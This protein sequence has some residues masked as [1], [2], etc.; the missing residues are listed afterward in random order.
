MKMPHFQDQ[1]EKS[2]E[3]IQSYEDAPFLGPKWPVCLEKRIFSENPI[4]NLA[5]FIHVYLNAKI[6]V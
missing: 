5:V 1:N 4:V 2:L 3:W 6:R